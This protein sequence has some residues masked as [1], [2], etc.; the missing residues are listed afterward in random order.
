MIKENGRWKNQIIENNLWK[1]TIIHFLN[2]ITATCP[3]SFVEEKKFSLAWHYRKAEPE[4]GYACSRELISLLE[5]IVHSYNL[6][7]LDGNKVVE[8]LTNETG[9][10]E[11][12][13]KLCD[14]DNYD[15]ILSIGDDATDEEMFEFFLHNSDAFSIKVGNGDTY[16]KYKLESIG[17]VMSLLKHLSA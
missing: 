8:I 3:E 10:G 2:K 15:F 16:A 14:Q 17:E 5:E 12:V 7:I 6:K 11:A 13:K 9:K 4:L 1:K